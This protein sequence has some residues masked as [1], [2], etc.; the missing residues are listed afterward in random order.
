VIEKI[1][2]ER[3][4]IQ[5]QFDELREMRQT[6]SERLLVDFKKAASQ[7]DAKAEEYINKL[8]SQLETLSVSSKKDKDSAMSSSSDGAFLHM[9]GKDGDNSRKYR[10]EIARLQQTNETLTNALRGR[11]VQGTAGGSIDDAKAIRRLYEDLTG[12]VINKVESAINREKDYH[13]CFHAI[14]ASDGYFSEY[15][16]ALFRLQHTT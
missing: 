12:L 5:G 1:A 9:N 3:D 6:E 2:R 7:R 15:K 14:F 16:A 8:K 11:T 10:E 4:Q 13:R